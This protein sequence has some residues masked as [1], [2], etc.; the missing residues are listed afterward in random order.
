MDT[1]N[2]SQRIDRRDIIQILRMLVL[3]ILSARLNLNPND[4]TQNHFK[5]S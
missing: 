2:F 1:T 3:T 5:R 4:T